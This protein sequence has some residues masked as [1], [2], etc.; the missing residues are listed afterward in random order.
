[1]TG[2]FIEHLLCR[3]ISCHDPT[4]SCHFPFPLSQQPSK[5]L[6]I[7]QYFCNFWFQVKS[8]FFD[9]AEYVTF[10]ITLSYRALYS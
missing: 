5:L 2:Q 10:P 7:L 3:L 6:F 1:M 8:Y 4:N 9:L